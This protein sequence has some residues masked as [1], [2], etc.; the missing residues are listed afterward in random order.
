MSNHQAIHQYTI[1]LEPTADIDPTWDIQL[2]MSMLEL[3]ALLHVSA[4]QAERDG[5]HHTA[6]R[7]RNDHQLISTIDNISDPKTVTITLTD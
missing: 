3:K 6:E 5:M 7:L 1:N 4:N 2:K